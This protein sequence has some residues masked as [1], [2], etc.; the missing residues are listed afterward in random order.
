M[1]IILIIILLILV[2][3]IRS[4]FVERQPE[5]VPPTSNNKGPDSTEDTSVYM[6]TFIYEFNKMQLYQ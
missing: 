4:I 3:C 2:I 1:I 5:K 6:L